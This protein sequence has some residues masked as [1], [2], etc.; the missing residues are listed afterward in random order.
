MANSLN[1]NILYIDDFSSA[2]DLSDRFPTGTLLVSIE[3]TR[4]T[5][6]LHWMEVRE[7]SATGKVIF[8]RRCNQVN[9]SEEKIYSPNGIW[10]KSLYIKATSENMNASGK[11]I[12]VTRGGNQT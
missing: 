4:P 12:I 9:Q 11:L 1:G 6:L 2:I 7:S 10:V 8:E 5:S 3:W